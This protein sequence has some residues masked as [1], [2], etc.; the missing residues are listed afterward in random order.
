VLSLA[1]YDDDDDSRHCE[2]WG[3]EFVKEIVGDKGLFMCSNEVEMCN[4][5]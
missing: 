4:G 1:V 2:E 5:W 3:E